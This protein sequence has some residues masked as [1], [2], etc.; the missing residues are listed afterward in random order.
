MLSSASHST[1]ADEAVSALFLP[2]AAF[3]A[4]RERGRGRGS[5]AESRRR[6]IIKK[7]TQQTMERATLAIYAPYAPYARGT[8]AQRKLVP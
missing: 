6:K 8:N 7:N 2:A 3:P 5:V 1:A 4:E